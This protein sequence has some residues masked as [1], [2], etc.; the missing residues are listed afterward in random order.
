MTVHPSPNLSEHIPYFVYFALILAYRR[1]NGSI[2]FVMTIL[3]KRLTHL[4]NGTYLPL[5][6]LKNIV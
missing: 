6:A 1:T 2:P 3:P 5:I 4:L